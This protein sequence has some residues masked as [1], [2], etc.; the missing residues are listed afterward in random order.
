M[1]STLPFTG[2]D[3]VGHVRGRH[4]P[5][6]PSHVESDR[7]LL[8]AIL[9]GLKPFLHFIWH[10]VPS[11]YP[12]LVRF[13]VQRKNPYFGRLSPGHITFLALIQVRWPGSRLNPSGHEHVWPPWTCNNLKTQ[14][15]FSI[16]V[17]S[18]LNKH[19][20][21]SNESFNISQSKLNT[22]LKVLAK[23]WTA[24]VFLC[25][26]VEISA[27]RLVRQELVTLPALTFSPARQIPAHLVAAAIVELALVNVPAQRL[28]VAEK[29]PHTGARDAA[30]RIQ[31]LLHIRE[32]LKKKTKRGCSLV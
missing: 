14:I 15:R 29:A 12:D 17:Q 25:T 8:R 19:V 26:L 13:C 5:S 22:D 21:N 16:F 4:S 28:V 1:G 10:L 3:S 18:K 27:T 11:L 6:S 31:T 20:I 23:T 24:A 30:F 2:C 32:I 9:N 7:H